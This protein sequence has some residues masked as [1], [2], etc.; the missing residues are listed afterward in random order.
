MWWIDFEPSFSPALCYESGLRL[1]ISQTILTF[2]DLIEIERGNNFYC[3]DCRS[4]DFG[5]DLQSQYRIQIEMLGYYEKQPRPSSAH[6][7]RSTVV[8]AVAGIWRQDRA[9]FD[10]AEN[11]LH[12]QSPNVNDSSVPTASAF[13]HVNSRYFFRV[14]VRGAVFVTTDRGD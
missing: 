5:E 13:A 10:G 4:R 12:V 2:P 7:N 9:R 3:V 1:N 14:A 6:R 8:P 11:D